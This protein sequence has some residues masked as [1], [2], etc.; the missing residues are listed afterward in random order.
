MSENPNRHPGTD[1]PEALMSVTEVANRYG[2]AA[3]TVRNWQYQG[4]LPFVKLGWL[5]R[6]KRSDVEALITK[7]YHG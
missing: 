6:F 3:K 2:V 7:G 4:R 1:E 5:V